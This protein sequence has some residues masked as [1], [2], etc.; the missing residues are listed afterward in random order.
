MKNFEKNLPP[1]SG[2]R[3]VFFFARSN[4]RRASRC[5]DAA[6]DASGRMDMDLF[7]LGSWVHKPV[8]PTQ[9]PQRSCVVFSVPQIGF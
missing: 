4:I 2:F 9:L 8:E 7:L 1:W 6:N 5:K 3:E